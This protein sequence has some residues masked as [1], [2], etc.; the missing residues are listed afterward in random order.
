MNIPKWTNESFHRSHLSGSVLCSSYT[1]VTT[2]LHTN[3]CNSELL[4]LLSTASV[5]RRFSERMQ[6]VRVAEAPTEVSL[7]CSAL[8]KL[9]IYFLL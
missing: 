5:S 6:D 4:F 2:Q 7:S 9:C 3:V 1:D 8:F